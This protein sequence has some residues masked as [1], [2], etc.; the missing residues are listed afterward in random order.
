M[1]VITAAQRF[2]ARAIGIEIDDDLVR[3]STARIAEGGLGSRA[4]IIYGDFLGADLRAAT[5][6]T[7]YQL[8]AVNELLRPLLEAQLR[9][10]ARV[11]SL[12]FPVP[13]WK[14]AR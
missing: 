13:G 6:V 10:G 7:L 5:I 11:V 8:P 4:R 3:L 2:G 12:D 1:T 14:P 9:P